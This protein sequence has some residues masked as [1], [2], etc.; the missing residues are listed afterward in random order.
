MRSYFNKIKEVFTRFRDLTHVGIGNLVS[1][2]I[3]G[4]FG[5]FIANLMGVEAFG[6]I[7]YFIAV[8]SVAGVAA[9]VG[10]SNAMIVYV[11]KGI[12]IQSSL[13]FISM[14]IS[15]VVAIVIYFLYQKIEV[16]LYVLG[17][18]PFTLFT[19]E[20]LG[21]KLYSRYSKIVII[22]RISLVGLSL[23]FY[24]LNG[25]IGIVLGYALSFFPY[26]IIVFCSFQRQEVSKV[27][28]RKYFGFFMNSYGLEI[29][30]VCIAYSDKIVIAPLFG[31]ALLGNYQLAYQVL[32]IM[33]MLPS[34][35][36]QYTLAQDA[37]GL[38]REK[39]KK[40]TMVAS[41]LLTV[42]VIT[43]GPSLLEIL[44]PKYSGAADII[45]II[46]LAAIPTSIN[47]MY[48]SKFLGEEK[49]KVVVIGSLL[50]LGVQFLGIIVL[51]KIF[52][53]YGIAVAI[54]LA[55]STECIYLLTTNKLL[56]SKAR[57]D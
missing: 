31:F 38:R 29:S 23:L 27:L 32:I 15:I 20:L 8:A 33:N 44:F 4:L 6:Q 55:A 52:G 7:S 40:L 45:Q 56:Q 1:T 18:V 14:L 2:G 34:V 53:I 9:L 50:Y 21:K 43:V 30:R 54:V 42:I 16:S 57:T 39:L 25:P 22:Q 37:V 13:Y 12:R 3:S 35:V 5:I 48:I 41:I 19:N 46:S 47:L 28:L 36:F 51:G 49:S 24:Y 17:Y 10:T 26:L 11:A